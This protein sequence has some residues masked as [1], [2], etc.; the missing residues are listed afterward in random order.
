MLLCGGTAAAAACFRFLH[1]H[2]FRWRHFRRAQPV[3]IL[4]QRKTRLCRHFIPHMRHLLETRHIKSALKHT[5]CGRCVLGVDIESETCAR[6][7]RKHQRLQ[8]LSTKHASLKIS[9]HT[10]INDAHKPIDADTGIFE[11]SFT[12]IVIETAAYRINIL[13]VKIFPLRFAPIPIIEFQPFVLNTSDDRIINHALH[14]WIARRSLF[15]NHRF[16]LEQQCIFMIVM[17]EINVTI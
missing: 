5:F 15:F 8:Q 13:A 16:N 14:S 11:L 10:K 4:A 9:S 6:R 12:L 7:K 3:L 2:R 17:H 1:Q